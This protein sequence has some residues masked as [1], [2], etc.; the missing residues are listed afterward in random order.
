MLS[1]TIE[2]HQGMALAF[3][4]LIIA[5]DVV[6][7]GLD[8][9]QQELQLVLNFWREFVSL[10]EVHEGVLRLVESELHSV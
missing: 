5:R 9:I 6:R 7:I 3:I 4:E 10:L 1:Y 8:A 2:F